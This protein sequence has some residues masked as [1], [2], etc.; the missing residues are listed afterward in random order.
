MSGEKTEEPT[1]KKKRDSKEKGQL[2]VGKDLLVLLKL[3]FGYWIIFAAMPSF[4]EGFSNLVDVIVHANFSDGQH[5]NAE[6]GTLAKDLFLVISLPIVVAASAV[7][8]FG[9]WLQTGFVFSAESATPSFKKFNAIGT[10]KEMFSKKSLVQLVISLIKVVLLAIVIYLVV[11]DAIGDIIYSYRSG[12]DVMFSLMWDL[13]Q[14]AVFISLALFIA[15]SALDWSVTY[16]HHLKQIMMS[17]SEVKDERKQLNGHPE[18]KRYLRQA[19][20]RLLN[21]SLQRVPNSKVVVAN[22]THIAIAL[23]YEP[24]VHDVPYILALGVDDD[25]RLIREMAEKHKIPI[26]R[27]I[28]LAR[29]IYADC[30]ED[31]Y[32][33]KQ[34]LELAAAVFKLVF[35]LSQQRN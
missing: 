28:R 15:L 34:H 35:S 21:S 26:V 2:A 5:L 25:A 27:N 14:K 10:I 1:D 33:Q 31:E 4:F 23:D 20:R 7:G 12:L 6:I 13:L 32:I 11:V 9:T 18:L 30:E 3:V 16:F 22:P 17:K 29:M 19:H 8:I 24:G